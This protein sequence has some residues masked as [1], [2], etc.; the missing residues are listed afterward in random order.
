MKQ[1][2]AGPAGELAGKYKTVRVLPRHGLLTPTK[3]VMIQKFGTTFRPLNELA[4][5]RQ[6]IQEIFLAKDSGSKF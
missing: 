2:L 4:L 3:L 1:S 5:A 6:L